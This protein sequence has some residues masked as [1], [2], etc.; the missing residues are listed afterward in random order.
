MRT[1][2]QYVVAFITMSTFFVDF[3]SGD[4]KIGEARNVIVP[5]DDAVYFEIR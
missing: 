2:T 4:D 1:L 3:W 5:D